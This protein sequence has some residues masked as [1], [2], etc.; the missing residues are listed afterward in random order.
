MD[1]GFFFIL[2]EFNYRRLQFGWFSHHE[3][4][5]AHVALFLA[6]NL[7]AGLCKISHRLFN[8]RSRSSSDINTCQLRSYN[9]VPLAL[10][11][12]YTRAGSGKS[13][14]KNHHR[15][16]C[17]LR[18]REDFVSLGRFDMCQNC[19]LASGKFQTRDAAV[20]K[21]NQTRA[22][23]DTD[24]LMKGQSQKFDS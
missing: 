16:F 4:I 11:I 21:C 24:N 22:F 3:L 19:G 18:Q 5:R 14:P 2:G 9:F 7:P 17:C 20:N 1:G 8:S 6:Q 12:F 10:S 13:L 15:P 23:K